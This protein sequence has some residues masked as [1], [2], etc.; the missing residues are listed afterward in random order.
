[1]G[2]I[3][4]KIHSEVNENL[5]LGRGRPCMAELSDMTP[6]HGHWAKH[7]PNDPTMAENGIVS[8]YRCGGGDRANGKDVNANTLNHRNV[9]HT[10]MS[11]SVYSTTPP[12]S[13]RP[14]V[15]CCPF[16]LMISS[17]FRRLP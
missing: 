13:R 4:S 9:C 11:Y 2:C 17:M 10:M 7:E 12:A 16:D 15:T 1:M 14:F 3:R 8:L 5:G 6:S